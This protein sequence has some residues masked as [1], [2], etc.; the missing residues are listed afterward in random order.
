MSVYCTPWLPGAPVPATAPA[1]LAPGDA[2]LAWF[3]ARP[4]EQVTNV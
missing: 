1:L 2:Q 3:A 4:A